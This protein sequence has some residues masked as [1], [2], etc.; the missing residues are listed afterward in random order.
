MSN[1]EFGALLKGHRGR[2]KLTQEKLAGKTGLSP[3]TIGMLER[4]EHAAPHAATLQLLAAALGLDGEERTEFVVAGTRQSELATAEAVATPSRRSRV[5]PPGALAE[6]AHLLAQ[7]VRSQWEPEAVVR[8][9][10]RPLPLTVRWSRAP[11]PLMDR[12]EVIL[13]AADG[14]R[15]G[16]RA[17]EPLALTGEGGI[18]REFRELP[19]PRLVVLG[20]WGS[21][22]TGQLVLLTLGLLKDREPADLVPVL[23]TVS[24][25]QP[26]RETFHG[27]IR[28]RLLEDHRGL[29][30]FGPD[31]VHALVHA[32]VLPLLDGLD[33][34]PPPARAAAMDAIEVAGPAQPLVVGCRTEEYR[35]L[36]AGGEPL[37]AA[38]A[39][40]LQP[41][42]PDEVVQFL[43]MSTVHEASMR[44]W[45][46]VFAEMLQHRDGPLARALSTPLMVSLA[47]TVYERGPREPAELL[48]R[49][50]YP[51]SE[52]IEDGLLDAL[53]PA[54]FDASPAYREGSG[55]WSA[56][57][58]RRCLTFLAGN[59]R[60]RGT[61]E[62]AWWEL[63][64]QRRYF[65][66]VLSIAFGAVFGL[67]GWLLRWVAGPS[68]MAELGAVFGVFVGLFPRRPRHAVVRFDRKLAA[69]LLRGLRGGV[70][71][72]VN[73][74]L[75]I[76]MLAGLL[77]W[78]IGGP[79]F[80]LRVGL[81][82]LLG[83]GLVAGSVFGLVVGLAEG[84]ARRSDEPASPASALSTD[85][86][87]LGFSLALLVVGLAAGFG[88][89][90]LVA[91]GLD[92]AFPLRVLLLSSI[93]LV[94]ARTALPLAVC[95][96]IA[97]AFGG[98]PWTLFQVFRAWFALTGR[99]PLRT[100]TFL[101]DARDLGVL[102]RDGAV[103]QFRHRRLQDR[104]AG[105]GPMAGP[106]WFAPSG[107]LGWRFPHCPDCDAVLAPWSRSCSR[108][109][110]PAAT[111]GA[112]MRDVPVGP[113]TRPLLLALWTFE[114]LTDRPLLRLLF[115]HWFGFALTLALAIFA[116][117]VMTVAI[118]T[119][120]AR[121]GV[122]PTVTAAA[123]ISVCAAV[124]GG[125]LLRRR[126][127][128]R[129]SGGS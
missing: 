49:G 24:S 8:Q 63:M 29:R 104:L 129:R 47:R 61:Y 87:A 119:L 93:W 42:R 55:R 7:R 28:R 77:A 20:G 100:M 96:L 107:Q 112:S 94:L 23:L 69:A 76:A 21:G 98:F 1:R 14:D 97:F 9:L 26:A 46:P 15:R 80:A 108:C 67:A 83:I 34:L 31:A 19:L 16:A 3:Q 33:E 99:L 89:V 122:G 110:A 121:I 88:L 50:R 74:S 48:D 102:R 41:V 11:Q 35:A 36:M 118:V 78:L 85:R 73:Y 128:R 124:A 71:F 45:D 68:E 12:D 70:K 43:R 59:L 92:R 13:A 126:L 79:W 86:S 114:W 75:V 25:W 115:G 117:V 72:G 44:R 113:V 120:S 17:G 95:G 38:A 125:L 90:T 127:T 84:I 51:S 116:P 5:P 58:A 27:W 106:R 111:A 66:P 91:T 62:L 18:V 105:G 52:V 6:A 103:Y 40:E 54:V 2:A 65:V 82:I 57:R 101:D 109:G 30:S 53:V 4:G 64:P 81:L 10:H 22:K 32:H 56:D 37:R 123:G 39:V 60:Q